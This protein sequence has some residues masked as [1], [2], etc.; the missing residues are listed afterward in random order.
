MFLCLGLYVCPLF[1]TGP[2]FAETSR[3]AVV[4]T[5][6]ADYS[7]GAH[8]VISVDPVG[9]PR[10]VYNDLAPTISDQGLSVYGKYFYRIERYNADSVT[11][12][13]INDPDAPIWQYSTLDPGDEGTSNP[14]NMVFVNDQKAYLLR[15]G[16]TRAWIVNP[17]ATSQAEFKIGELD[18]SA[19]GDQDG[20]PEMSK[21]V[22]IGD[23]LYLELS[24]LDQTNNWAPN[25]PYLAVFDIYT[26]TE[27]DTGVPNPDGVKGIPL[28]VKN[29]G[30]MVYHSANFM[31]YIQGSGRIGSEVMGTPTEYS[32]GIVSVN[33]FTYETSLILDD[34]DET[35]HPYGNISG[36]SVVSP[37]KGYFV[38]Y[39]GWGDNTLYEFNPST[40]QV[41]GAVHPSLSN[42][43]IPGMEAGS[44]VDPNAMLWVCDATYA[45]VV[46]VNTQTH[47]ID[48]R[49][50]TNLNPQ[51]VEF[52]T[53]T[54]Q[55]ESPDDEPDDGD[56]D[57]D[58]SNCFITTSGF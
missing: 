42:I 10:T 29:T 9:G 26:D 47:T 35:N 1:F 18:L 16:S 3:W 44:Y 50:S 28:P 11:K 8:S 21:G 53:V 49:I 25:T 54:T 39:A 38:G 6:A 14:Q 17:S 30:A 4:L 15:S 24:R 20:L 46:I 57:D 7:S 19:Y 22:I 56:D 58:G 51:R 2:A 37:S 33:P 45:E 43:N 5:A 23:K 32:G 27:I 40:G 55:E 13:S 34:G 36:L 31:L 52:L 41:Y 12:F 48:E